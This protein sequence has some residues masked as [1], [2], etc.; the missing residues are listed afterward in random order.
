MLF[1]MQPRD[2]LRI[3]GIIR[4]VNHY[5]FPHNTMQQNVRTLTFG[6]WHPSQYWWDQVP[7]HVRRDI[8]R[9]KKTNENSIGI[10]IYLY[11]TTLAHLPLTFKALSSAV[12]NSYSLNK[13][14]NKPFAFV[15]EVIIVYGELPTHN[16]FNNEI[17]LIRRS[18]QIACFGKLILAFALM[19]NATWK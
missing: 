8:C 13:S 12:L 11:S 16:S 5:I 10:I 9:Q 2:L 19:T 18:I 4:L 7:W 17:D 6:K 14:C 15:L 1:L 3:D